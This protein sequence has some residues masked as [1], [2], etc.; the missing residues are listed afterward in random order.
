M[1]FKDSFQ[2]KYYTPCRISIY[3]PWKDCH[4]D[5][6]CFNSNFYCCRIDPPYWF[7]AGLCLYPGF[8]LFYDVKL[9]Y[10]KY[11]KIVKN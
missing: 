2:L 3:F 8:Y 11:I 6:S 1:D 9:A 4:C 10:I 5:D 7:W